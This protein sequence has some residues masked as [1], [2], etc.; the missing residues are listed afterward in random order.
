MCDAV[1]TLLVGYVIAKA[2]VSKMN[3]AMGSQLHGLPFGGSISCALRS[4]GRGQC[5]S[6]DSCDDKYK[7]P[8]KVSKCMKWLKKGK[9][10][11][12][13]K[14]G[15]KARSKCARTCSVC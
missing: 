2:F 3:K 6:P 15:K 7:T 11:K 4:T 8:E 1:T 5:P 9:C 12:D 13:S 14:L 10:S